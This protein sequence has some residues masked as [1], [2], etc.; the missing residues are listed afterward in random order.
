MIVT[1]SVTLRPAW[2]V[3]SSLLSPSC[4]DDVLADQ[5]TGPPTAVST[6]WPV[7][8]VPMATRPGDTARVP[9]GAGRAGVTLKSG[10]GPAAPVGPDP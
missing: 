9:A 10:P 7:L 1:S 6:I 2:S 4:A 8:P 3:P 5:L